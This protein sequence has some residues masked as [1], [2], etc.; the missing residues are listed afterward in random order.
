MPENKMMQ[1]LLR[2]T[3]P[4]TT[5]SAIDSNKLSLDFTP[6]ASNF[7]NIPAAASNEQSLK[8]Y[9]NGK[10]NVGMT[11]ALV[12]GSLG[13][14]A[15][16]TNNMFQAR[17]MN[18]SA[19]SLLAQRPLNYAAYRQNVNYAAEENFAAVARTLSD[20]NAMEGLQMAMMGASGFD[21]SAGDQRIIADTKQKAAHDVYLQ[22]RSAYLQ[23]FELWRST[24]M[25][26]NRLLAAS[27]MAKVQAKYAKRTAYTNL[28]SGAISTAAGV[29][30][31]AYGPYLQTATQKKQA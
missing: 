30:S 7:N 3:L 17:A 1:S 15:D 13:M 31:A 14:M 23:S 2:Q 19:A 21:V 4:S 22:N 20:A 25:E 18:A 27:K 9:T 16:F 24:E 5:F 6:K 10:W 26:N 12:S 28:V 29:M 8:P 11:S